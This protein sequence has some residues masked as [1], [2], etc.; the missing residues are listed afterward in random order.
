MITISRRELKRTLLL[1]SIVFVFTI[2]SIFYILNYHGNSDFKT[3]A[4]FDFNLITGFILNLMAGCLIAFV[5][6][7]EGRR[8]E[9]GETEN[10][11]NIIEGIDSEIIL[12]KAATDG[13]NSLPKR[14]RDEISRSI[15]ELIEVPW[16]LMINKYRIVMIRSNDGNYYS[17]RIGIFRA[18]FIRTREKFIITNVF[19]GLG[20]G[21]S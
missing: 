12:L 7:N 9:K 8:A 1:V 20:L 11:K 6:F 18:T 3:P 4:K 13:L 5:T 16:D 15:Q 17:M 2:V 21:L 14:D 10:I 19:R